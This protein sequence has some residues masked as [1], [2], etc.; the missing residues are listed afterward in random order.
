MRLFRLASSK[1]VLILARCPD[2]HDEH[3]EHYKLHGMTLC[4]GAVGEHRVQRDVSD[5]PQVHGT[6]VPVPNLAS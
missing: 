2:E 1:A 3:D 6:S 4:Q 5:W